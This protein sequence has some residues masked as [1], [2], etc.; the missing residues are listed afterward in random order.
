MMSTAD[1]SKADATADSN[2]KTTD[3]E[4][5]QNG[6]SDAKADNAST[7]DAQDATAAK[8]VQELEGQLKEMK[9]RG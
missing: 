5:N 9:V 2:K 4:S 8:R 7:V 1:P 6:A 3:A